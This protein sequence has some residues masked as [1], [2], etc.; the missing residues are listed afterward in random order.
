MKVMRVQGTKSSETRGK[1]ARI[2]NKN[3]DNLKLFLSDPEIEAEIRRA[4]ESL[5]LPPDGLSENDIQG[6]NISMAARSDEMRK[7]PVFQRLRDQIR[8]NVAERKIDHAM[9]QKQLDMV[10]EH[11]PENRLASAVEYIIRLYNLPL[12]YADSLRTYIVANIISAPA[13]VFSV[14]SQHDLLTGASRVVVD[15]Y[16][17]LTDADLK[18]VKFMVNEVVGKHLPEFWP[19]KDIDKKLEADA[20]WSGDR[21]RASEAG[22]E[23]YPVSAMEVAEEIQQEFGSKTAP[24]YVYE[25]KRE[26]KELKR[27]RFPNLGNTS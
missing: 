20:Q 15:V 23:R 18:R 27:K 7:S 12:N 16:A 26:L 17:K 14:G 24:S 10:Y 25:S 4:R 11:L 19:I 6:W 22:S 5:H 21:D 3:L 13:N 9:A 2:K 1:T 8:K